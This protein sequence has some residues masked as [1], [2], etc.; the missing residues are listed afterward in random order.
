M[1]N[2]ANQQS[3]TKSG[4][5]YCTLPYLKSIQIKTILIKATKVILIF[6]QTNFKH[7]LYPIIYSCT[8]MMWLIKTLSQSAATPTPSMSP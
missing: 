5:I 7:I 1:M 2:D 8:A 6:I 3:P 4:A